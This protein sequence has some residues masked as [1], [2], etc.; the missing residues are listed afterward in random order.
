MKERSSIKL[1]ILEI[2]KFGIQANKVLKIPINNSTRMEPD[3]NG[4][5]VE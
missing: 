1:N 4:K 2:L 3:E 5:S